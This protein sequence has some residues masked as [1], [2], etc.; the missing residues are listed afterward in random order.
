MKLNKKITINEAVAKIADN[1]QPTCGIVF[2]DAIRQ[3]EANKEH[4]KQLFDE[5][6]IQLPNEDRFAHQKVNG[7][8][9]MKKM[10]LA[11]SLFTEWVGETRLEESFAQPNLILKDG[12]FQFDTATGNI[13]VP[14]SIFDDFIVNGKLNVQFADEGADVYTYVMKS[15]NEDSITMQCNGEAIPG[16]DEE[17]ADCQ[18]YPIEKPKAKDSAFISA[19]DKNP[20]NRVKAKDFGYVSAG[21]KQP[22]KAAMKESFNNWDSPESRIERYETDLP[23]LMNTMHDNYMKGRLAAEDYAEALKIAYDALDSVPYIDEALED[24]QRYPVEKPKAKDSQ[25]ISKEDKQPKSAVKAKDSQFISAGEKDPN[26]AFGEKRLGESLDQPLN[27]EVVYKYKPNREPLGEIIQLELTEGEWGYR[28]EDGKQTATRLPSANYMPSKL[29]ANWDRNDKYAITVLA[30]NIEQ[31]ESAIKIATK[32]DREYKI[33]K[34]SKPIKGDTLRLW[35]YMDEDKDFDEPYKGESDI[36]DMN[37]IPAKVIYT[38]PVEETDS[39]EESI[40]SEQKYPIQSP[41]A[42]ELDITEED[43]NQELQE[44]NVTTIGVGNFNPNEGKARETWDKIVAADKIG[45]LDFMLEDMYPNG[46]TSKELNGLLAD[47]SAWVL[48]M[49]GLDDTDSGLDFASDIDDNF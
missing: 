43:D 17:I 8:K 12:Q 33:E 26:K 30:A 44:A 23:E 28:E 27:E 29:G 47:D 20:K 40:E 2:A 5:K 31:L 6:K 48:H 39:V 35:I 11:E 37:N 10:K 24:S 9:E 49:L 25:F 16:I 4:V 22:E 36:V 1:I 3:T 15:E 45:I 42:E 18:K 34:L 38:N 13:T 21:D 41:I 7:T 19:E 46:P 32:Y 14:K